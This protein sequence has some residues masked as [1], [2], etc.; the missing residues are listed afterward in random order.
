MFRFINK[1]VRLRAKNIPDLF[2][3]YGQATFLLVRVRQEQ[4]YFFGIKHSCLL[5]VN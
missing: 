4:K 1:L 2:D 3:Y 5:S